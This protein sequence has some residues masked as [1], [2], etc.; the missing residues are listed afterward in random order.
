MKAL[1]P[2]LYEP[3]RDQ[4]LR[5]L[6][7]CSALG[8]ISSLRHPCKLTRECHSRLFWLS[9]GTIDRKHI[10]WLIGCK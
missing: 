4:S 9:R 1:L 7:S 3:D 10:S 8:S 5:S 6:L 2:V